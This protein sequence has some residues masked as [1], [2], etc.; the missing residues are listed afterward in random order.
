MDLRHFV[1]YGSNQAPFSRSLPGTCAFLVTAIR[2]GVRLVASAHG[3]LQ[4]LLKNP[5]LNSLLGGTT[6]VT[7]GDKL[8]KATQGGNKVRHMKENTIDQ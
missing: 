1:T 7:L 4:S 3:D 5:S 2:R 6:S 8:A